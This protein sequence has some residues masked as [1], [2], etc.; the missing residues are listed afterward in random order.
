MIKKKYYQY[1][2]RNKYENLKTKLNSLDDIYYELK[3][4][5]QDFRY[6]TTLI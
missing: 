3:Q 1:N 6:E 2:L 5:N 4:K